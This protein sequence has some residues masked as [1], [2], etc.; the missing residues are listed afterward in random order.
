MALWGMLL[1]V[2]Y[3][4]SI[5]FYHHL[6]L[7]QYVT[8]INLHTL[9]FSFFWVRLLGPLPGMILL[10]PLLAAL[11][12]GLGGRWRLA[13]WLGAGLLALAM[14]LS[15]GLLAVTY[16]GLTWQQS[17][18]WLH[19]PGRAFSQSLRLGIRID[20]LVALMVSLTTTISF[21]VHLYAMA[22]L[23]TA[24]RRY[25]ALTGAF[26]SAMLGFWMA[27]SLLGRFIGWELIGWGS[28]L[29]IGFWH[30]K[31]DAARHSTKA[32]LINQVGSISLL[33]GILF[34]GSELGTW[35]LAKLATLPPLS[36][37]NHPW[38]GIARFCLVA[39]LCA[40]SAQWPWFNWLS[41]AMTAPTPASALIHSAT[42]VGAGVY[43]LVGLA[44]VLGSVML[45]GIACVGAM[46][47]L[48]G[49][50]A[51]LTQQHAKQ[52]LAYSTI[53]QLGYMVMAVGVG[54]SSVGIFHFVVH[55]FAKACL[56]L[57]VGIA[58]QQI[59][60]GNMQRM[61]GLRQVL[62]GVFVVYLF[63]ASSLLGVPG[64]AGS[65]SK[66][67]ILAYTWAWAREQA[68]TGSYW[69]YA[70]PGL[71]WLASLLGV[72]YIGRQ[73]YLVFLGTPRWATKEHPSLPYRAA[74]VMQG[75]MAVLAL[76][77]LGYWYGPLA[78]GIQDS[79]L[80]QRIEGFSEPLTATLAHGVLFASLLALLLGGCLCL[81]WQRKGF[82]VLPTSWAQLSLRG[83]YLD[84]LAHAMAQQVLR[85]SRMAARFEQRIFYGGVQYTVRGYV[86]LAQVANRV[87][88]KTIGSLLRGISRG[89][90]AL[91][92]GVSWI[93]R[94]L[95]AGL[96]L[97]VAS[98]PR[99][100]GTAH[101]ITQQGS[102]QRALLWM[103][104]GIGLLIGAIY[105]CAVLFC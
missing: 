5:H 74:W 79:W 85:F 43:W 31:P 92:Y 103:C 3:Y 105:W 87:D 6:Y 101:R 61:G 89:Y 23:K 38:L 7:Y 56:F 25:G 26:V 41:S 73:I 34:L 54:A 32:W 44:P 55:A 22:Y 15:W 33:I 84:N 37:E 24:R 98:A 46:T 14:L 2:F 29:L 20:F 8:A 86:A 71:A 93:D 17:F 82:P 62:P 12:V 27:D 18:T 35:D 64:F 36:L 48:M 70:V 21:L 69:A 59:G 94:Q 81:A 57:C 45:S 52:V 83:W 39:G 78:G 10:L 28:Y 49:A 100:L 9:L 95:V 58:S 67:A 97:G 16:Y 91:A 40:K 99:Y 19:L 60:T 96:V 102:W 42:L 65:F 47:A 88:R 53:S 104:L 11:A 75:S 77:T 51:A 1:S 13:H 63:A 30:A 76:G 4:F 68:F 80:W 72:V 66:E 50:Y 90:V